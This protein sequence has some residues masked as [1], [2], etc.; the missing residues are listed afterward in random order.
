M[1]KADEVIKDF[2]LKHAYDPVYAREYYLR[3][4]KL[5][6]GKAAGVDPQ[7]QITYSGKP[8]QIK[9]GKKTHEDE[10]PNV[11][12]SGSKLVDFNAGPDGLGKAVYADGSV[13]TSS[14]WKKPASKAEGQLAAGAAKRLNDAQRKL[15]AARTQ[16]SKLENPKDKKA[17]LNRI[18]AAEKKLSDAQK[19]VK[20]V[21]KPILR[22][23]VT[24]GV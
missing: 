5:K 12:P 24:S 18:S 22:R 14:G 3:N 19:K 16:A 21:A 9:P 13:F 2:V 23:G 4:R 15:S 7:S 11:S 6:G 20:P 10:T 8:V 17:L 1:T